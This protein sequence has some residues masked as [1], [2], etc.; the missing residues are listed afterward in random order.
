MPIQSCGQSVQRCARETGRSVEHPYRVA[1]KASALGAGSDVP[2][3]AYSSEALPAASHLVC[4]SAACSPHCCIWAVMH[5]G[6]GTAMPAAE[7][8]VAVV[9]KLSILPRVHEQSL[10]PMGMAAEQEGHLE[11]FL[12]PISRTSYLRY[13]AAGLTCN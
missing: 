9:W 11:Q 10:A 7:Q 13:S 4:M 12:K 1:E 5:C 6:T 2:K 8:A 3:S